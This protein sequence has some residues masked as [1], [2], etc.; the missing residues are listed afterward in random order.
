LALL[1]RCGH[2]IPRG[3]TVL[4]FGCGDGRL[5]DAYRRAGFDAWGC[6]VALPRPD[7]YLKPLAGDGFLPFATSSFDLIVSE[8][9]LEHVAGD[10]QQ[11]MLEFL[12]ILRPGGAAIHL[13]PPRTGLI[14]SHTMVPL[15]SMVRRP[16]WLSLWARAGVRADHQRGMAA[17]AVAAQNAH[18]LATRTNYLSRRHYRR[19]T[20]DFTRAR[21]VE[22]EWLAVSARRPAVRLFARAAAIAPPLAWLY[23]ALYYRVLLLETS[24]S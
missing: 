1:A 13:F 15:A 24:H 17:D 3:A 14:E 7:E 12:R 4:D 6:D 5:V 10:Q 2:D 11:Q 21:F 19:I 8:T 9:V 18:Y 20:R 23:G 16:L 22:R